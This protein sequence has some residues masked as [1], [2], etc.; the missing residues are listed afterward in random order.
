MEQT[1]RRHIV[2]EASQ[3]GF[4]PGEWPRNATLDGENFVQAYFDYDRPHGDPDR[5]IVRVVY[6]ATRAGCH[7]TLEVLND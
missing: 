3:M 7:D 5:E 6:Y 1:I 4:P 2:R